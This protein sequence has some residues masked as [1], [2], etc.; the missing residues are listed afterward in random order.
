VKAEDTVNLAKRLTYRPELTGVARALGLR[1]VL[2]K[3]YYHWAAPGGILRLEVKRISAQF[4]VR[5]P[6]EL[7]ALDG[8]GIGKTIEWGERHT[9]ELIIDA[10]R[11]GGIVYDVGANFGLYTVL[12]AKAVGEQGQV[13]AFEPDSRSYERLQEN[14]KLNGVGNIRSFPKALGDQNGEAKLYLEEER[15]WLS[16]LLVRPGTREI[17]HQL[18]EVVEGDRLREVEHLPLP[19]AVKIDVEGSEYAVIQ[20]L[21]H[22]L[23]DPVCELVC[24]EIHPH[25][26]PAEVKP[27]QVLALL[28]SLGF[29]RI[30][31]YPRGLEQH[32]LC[33]KGQ[34]CELERAGR[35]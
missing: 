3:L 20:G 12:L 25:L 31:V 16:S 7:R 19:Q 13:I 1:Q 6:D 30:D 22:T 33:Y 27:A 29:D 14:L 18:V 17:S 10:L 2:R 23:A 34:R 11:S 21:R 24:C 35:S 9:L 32:A 15:T 8:A 28:K 4:Y 5:T 26:L